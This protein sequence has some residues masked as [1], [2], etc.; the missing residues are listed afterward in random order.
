MMKRAAEALRRQDWAAIV[1]EFLLVVTGVLFAFQISQWASGR[2]DRRIR[3]E[4]VERLLHEAEQDVAILQELVTDQK[5]QVLDKMLVAAAN[6]RNPSPP[7]QIVDDFRAGIARSAVMPKPPAPDSVYQELIASGRFG[8]T[9][10]TRMRDAVSAYASAMKYLDQAI[11]YARMGTTRPLESDSIKVTYD[12]SSERHRRV[13]IDFS[14]LAADQAVQNQFLARLSVQQ[15]VIDNYGTAL[16][17]AK[18]MCQ[19]VARVAGKPCRP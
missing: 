6:L 17:A 3:E 13:D 19:E 14:E 8:A 1:I 10:D 7:A 12:P 16:N 9:G 2:D 11:D 18:L 4:S 15:F 5:E